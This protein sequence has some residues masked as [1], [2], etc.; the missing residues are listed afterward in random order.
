MG[1]DSRQFAEPSAVRI[2]TKKST[3]PMTARLNLEALPGDA[4]SVYPYRV[5]LALSALATVAMVIWILW[6]CGFG[7]DFRDEGFYF[8]WMTDPYKYEYSLTQFWFVYRPFFELLGHSITG[9]R[10]FN[11]VVTLALA[12]MLADRVLQLVGFEARPWQRAMVAA[13]L[14]TSSLSFL[15][16]WLPTPSYNWLALQ[17]LMLTC[18]GLLAVRSDATRDRVL[19]ASFLVGV[20]GWLTFMAKPPTGAGLAL[21]ALIYLLVRP[22][23]A[24]RVLVLSGLIACA[25]LLVSALAMD[26]SLVRFAD[27]YLTGMHMAEVMFGVKDKNSL[28]PRLGGLKLDALTRGQI[29]FGFAA[30][31]CITWLAGV[32][33]RAA[34]VTSA[35]VLA[36]LTVSTFLIVLGLLPGLT[37][38][39]NYRGLL[40]GVIPLAS[41][42][43]FLVRW[44]KLVDMKD[45]WRVAAL[46]MVMPLTY[47]SGTA[48]DN[49]WQISHAAVFWVIAAAIL[50]AS[51]ASV[52]WSIRL[53]RVMVVA[54]ATQFIMAVIIQTGIEAPYG[55][56]A[57]LRLQHRETSIG[58]PSVHLKLTPAVGT[59]FED[60][61]RK[62]REA[63]FVEGTPVLD[64]T[65]RS[66]TV[67]YAMRAG[68]FGSA[69]IQGGYPGSDRHVVAL[70]NRHSCSELARVWLLNQSENEA[71]IDPH[72]LASF[73]ADLTTDYDVATTIVL[74]QPFFGYPQR[75]TQQLLRPR[76]TPAEAEA[77]CLEVRGASFE[78]AT[79]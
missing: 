46:L 67:L 64:L 55:Q 69:W 13:G 30:L 48:N 8:V 35:V 38:I 44:P 73:G 32:R 40:L 9:I 10:Q 22:R 47:V 66:P 34:G 75:W 20:G 18:T 25:L 4:S 76:R 28:L 31:T 61:E 79:Q 2:A 17:G 12:W 78:H 16:I 70:L 6:F 62:P 1:W 56:P 41:A 59:Y 29:L 3:D 52:P 33:S 63:G 53:P 19:L 27:R 24:W 42:A 58:L 14:A 74:E 57:S 49:W 50:A 68:L 26:G 45:A 71:R 77:R 21:C 65:G 51:P 11:V 43:A 36:A 7:I 15:H 5:V 37:P 60:A 23:P 39:R 72:V 54:I